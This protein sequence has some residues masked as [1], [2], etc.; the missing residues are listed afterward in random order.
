MMPISWDKFA[1]EI[2][3]KQYERQQSQY[4]TNCGKPIIMIRVRNDY[5]ASVR[6]RQLT[7][8]LCWE[9]AGGTT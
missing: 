3:K 8:N 1:Q 2:I 7:Y 4:C 9:C 6:H 5:E